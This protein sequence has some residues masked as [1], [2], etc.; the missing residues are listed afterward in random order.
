MTFCEKCG[1][2]AIYVGDPIGN[3]EDLICQCHKEETFKTSYNYGWICPKCGHVYAPWVHSCK[4][5]NEQCV[6]TSVYTI[7]Y[8]S[9]FITT[10]NNITEQGDEK[11]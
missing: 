5:C 6:Y 7:T 8:S 9:P 11:K 10:S 4:H 1:K 2:P 3:I